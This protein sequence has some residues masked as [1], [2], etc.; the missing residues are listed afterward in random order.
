MKYPKI[1]I[2]ILLLIFSADRAFCQ[3]KDSVSRN[4]I[5]IFID[6]T[7]CDLDYIRKEV[8]YV[9]YVRDPKEAQVHIIITGQTTGSSGSEY[10]IR[11]LGQK[12]FEGKND[13]LKFAADPNMTDDEIRKGILKILQMGLM[14]YV[15]GSPLADQIGITYEHSGENKNVKDIWDYW[16]YDFNISA[17]L[18]GEESHQQMY[19]YGNS[20]AN[21][22]TEKWKY[23]FSWYY[24]FNR[25]KYKYNNGTTDTT[26][27][28]QNKSWGFS[29]LVVKSLKGDHWA[30]GAEAGVWSSDYSNIKINQYIGPAIEYDIFPYSQST[31][32]QIRIKY[33]VDYKH[34]QYFD[35]TLYNKLEQLLF[36][37]QLSIASEVV[38]KWG[39]V[40]ASLTGSSYLH[41][42][43]L[44]DINFNG[45]VSV[46]IFKGFSVKFSGFAALIHDQI[47][48]SKTGLTT[49]EILTQQRQMQTQYEYYL[50]FG[51]TYQFGSI[52]NNIV[53]PRFGE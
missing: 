44:F 1:F 47:Y 21:R 9:N 3:A 29:S 12:D 51:I 24:N 38:Q 48:L 46:R 18:Y 20:Y 31:S 4:A 45:S 17:Y 13:T 52:Y 27:I 2:L 26:Y 50:N 30:A 37:Q 40:S 10:A 19:Y 11:F 39:S 32:K 49:D 6:C 23:E 5:R 28:Y 41:D 43:S 15:A 53:N 33:C 42:F 8:T 7:S 22:I 35:T 16:L 25:N 14:P 34:I 36:L